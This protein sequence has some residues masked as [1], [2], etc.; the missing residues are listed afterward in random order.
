MS[1]NLVSNYAANVAQ[2]YLSK[3]DQ[4]MTSS[5]AKLTAGTRVLSASDD[6]ASLAIG[7]R[8]ASDLA[9]LQ[10]AAVN[11]GQASSM[12]QIADGGMSTISDIL[13]RMKTLAVQSAS[14]QVADTERAM[15]NQEFSSLQDEINGIVAGTTFSGQQLLSGGGNAASTAGSQAIKLTNGAFNASISGTTVAGNP[16]P[17]AYLA[18]NTGSQNYQST[19]KITLA[20][21]GG[22][23]VSV[24]LSGSEKTVADVAATLNGDSSFNAVAVA[25][26]NAQG[27]LEVHT[28]PG[29]ADTNGFAGIASLTYTRGG[30]DDSGI[31]AGTSVTVDFSSA[32]INLGNVNNGGG[33]KAGDLIKVAF[34]DGSTDYVAIKSADIAY[35]G[36]GQTGAGTG[37]AGIIAHALQTN[38]TTGFFI[39]ASTIVDATS[40][41]SVDFV[42]NSTAPNITH[43]SYID[44]SGPISNNATVAGT[45]LAQTPNTFQQ[46]Q[47]T[48][49]LNGVNLG[50]G[51]KLTF[52]VV[53]A[54]G[55]SADT[56]TETYTLT[57]A[58]V[59][60]GINKLVGDLQ[61]YS[62]HWASGSA[63]FAG[64]NFSTDGNGNI[65]VAA[66][67]T[68]KVFRITNLQYQY[69]ASNQNMAQASVDFANRT[70]QN[71]DLLSWNVGGATQT[72]TVGAASGTTLSSMAAYIN[73][74][75]ASG[76]AFDGTTAYATYDG[77]L[78][79]QST[80]GN[81]TSV[82]FTGL[83]GTQ[84]TSGGNSVSGGSGKAYTVNFQI[85]VGSRASDVLAVQIDNMQATTLGVDASQ[86][87]VL[88]V[89]G[90]TASLNAIN[91]AIDK[92]SSGRASVGAQ[93]NRLQF[94]SQALATQVENTDAAR[95]SLLDLNIASEMANFT[96][97]QVLE[98]AGVSMLAQANQMPQNLLRLFR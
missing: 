59:A 1:L 82:N 98:Q 30:L 56:D 23:T 79:L 86:Q 75:N 14:G 27:N 12:L 39:S 26:L 21:N 41:T 66:S 40:P 84:L 68:N 80:S 28:L 96:S 8:L 32:G 7:T 57:S 74:N 38:D 61:A 65:S 87:N 9:G 52:K 69:A 90:A 77:K 88:S 37:N 97:K 94:A 67:D 36:S 70:F 55:T 43:I 50:A 95:S 20:L 63:Q 24:S 35:V 11:A 49:N 92:V 93:I 25:S 53:A 58:D 81:Y 17:G 48:I 83:D 18:L 16:G 2:R 47:G 85:G 15:L 29:T 4:Q 22:Q 19:D 33:V 64:L 44:Q 76:Q 34:A 54:D 6:A 45:A 60:G 71:G 3:T 73:A 5:L 13:V 46:G 91:A 89:A 42:V 78:L 10:Q 31:T 72:L 51:D 62:A